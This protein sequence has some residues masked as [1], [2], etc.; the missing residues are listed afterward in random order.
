MR[1]LYVQSPGRGLPRSAHELHGPRVSAGDAFGHARSEKGA[2]HTS[3]CPLSLF[4]GGA[5][6]GAALAP[7]TEVDAHL[8]A[9]LR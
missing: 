4:G 2:G 9:H 1:L 8:T 7:A 6:R 3:G 5:L